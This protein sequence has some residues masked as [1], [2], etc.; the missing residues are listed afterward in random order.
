MFFFI[1]FNRYR[2]IKSVAYTCD[3]ARGAVYDDDDAGFPLRS[4][5]GVGYGS[6]ID[7]EL[8]PHNGAPSTLDMDGCSAI[9]RG[10]ET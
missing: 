6:G 4:T 10:R 5:D 7:R 3:L 9:L 1:S 8:S 2:P